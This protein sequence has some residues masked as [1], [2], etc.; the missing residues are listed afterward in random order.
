MIDLVGILRSIGIIRGPHLFENEQIVSRYPFVP[1][2]P[3]P[4]KY[5]AF[6][7]AFI[8]IGTPEQ[9][10]ERR[11]KWMAHHYGEVT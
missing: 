8:G 10:E 5:S 3:K 1:K 7:R 6:E 4:D 2:T 9:E 11:R